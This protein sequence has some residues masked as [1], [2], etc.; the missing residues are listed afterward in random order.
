MLAGEFD[1]DHPISKKIARVGRSVK[2]FRFSVVSL[3]LY[4]QFV[5]VFLKKL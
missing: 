1:S 4:V 2:N 5:R 3:K